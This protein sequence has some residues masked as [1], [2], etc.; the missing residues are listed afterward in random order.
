MKIIFVVHGLGEYAQAQSVADVLQQ[1]K[2]NIFF[3]SKDKLIKDIAFNDN[4]SVIDEKDDI[5]NIIKNSDADA[6]FLCNS[7]TNIPYKL[8]RSSKIKKVFSL[9]SNWL[10]NNDKLNG[11]N[12]HK[13]LTYP[14]IDT[15]YALFPRPIFEANLKK[16]GGYYEI[17]DYFKNR[18]YCPGFVP[19]GKSLSQSEKQI[20]RKKYN[21]NN[22]KKVISLYFGNKDFHSDSFNKMVSET[23]RLITLI[24]NEI[25]QTDHIDIEVKRLDSDVPDKR[26]SSVHFDEELSISDLVIMHYG[27]GTLARIFHKKIPVICFIPQVE[28]EIHS[29]YFELSPLIK[30]NAIKHFFFDKFEKTELKDAI[31]SLL[32]DQTAI[33]E[34][35]NN[36][37]TIFIKGEGNLIKHFYQQFK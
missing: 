22:G 36:Q 13:Y 2:E 17:S 24:I 33:K 28:N 18:I 8:T 27:Y 4:F 31:L 11:K 32:L 9:D 19:S 10:F 20:L 30:K 7:H 1:K 34:I 26:K 25:K 14:W 37:E 21:I 35:K 3:I 29:N 5:N 6:L 15:I 12:Y 16:K 23:L